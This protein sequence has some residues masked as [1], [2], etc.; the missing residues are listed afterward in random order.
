MAEDLIGQ[1]IKSYE[2]IEQIGRGGFGVVYRARQA[3]VEREVAIKVILPHYACQPEFIRRFECEAQIVA[4]LEHPHI[5]PLYDYW[6]DPDGAFLVMRFLRGGTLKDRMGDKPWDINMT[7]HVIRQLASALAMA[8]QNNIIHRDL[9]P[10]NVLLDERENIYLS[11]FGIAKT[12]NPADASIGRGEF[13]GSPAYVSPE[14]ITGE[15]VGTQTDIYSLGI[16]CFELLSGTHPFAESR[17][18]IAMLNAHIHTPLPSIK[19]FRPDLSDEADEVLHRA[20]AKNPQNRYQD[21]MEFE[22]AFRHSL[23]VV[24]RPV[25]ADAF[26]DLLDADLTPLQLTEIGNP[27]RGLRAFQEADADVFFGRESLT[28]SLLERLQAS[29]TAGRFIALVGPSG[30][31]KSSVVRAGLLPA[32]RRGEVNGSDRWF[33]VEMLP[34][35]HPLEEL[36]AGLLRVAVNPPDTLYEQLRSDERGLVRAIKRCLPDD[37][38]TELLLFID[39]FEEAF[40]L[41]TDPAEREH[42]LGMLYTALSDSNSRLRLVITLRADFYDR[43]LLHPHFGG[44][45]KDHTELVLP[46]SPEELERAITEPARRAKVQLEAGLA[47]AIIGDVHQEP[48]ALPL[49]Q[50]AMTELYDRRTGNTLTLE[51]YHTIGGAMGALARRA[52]ELYLQ[53]DAGQREAVRQLFLRLVTL[54]EGAEDTRRRAM[55]GELLHLGGHADVMQSVVDVLGKARL[56]TFDRDPSTRSATVEVAH[57]ELL[58][59]WGRLRG[60]LD[61]SREDIRQQRR[62]ASLADDWVQSGR[63]ASV[64]LRGSRL[65]EVAAWAVSTSL[66]LSVNERTFLEVSQEARRQQV[67]AEYNRQLREKAL[68]QQSRNRL[69]FLVG[70]FAVATIAGILLSLFAFRQRDDAR[71]ARTAA[72][73]ARQTSEAN[74]VIAETQAAISDRRAQELQSLSLVAAARLNQSQSPDLALALGLQ[75]AQIDQPPTEVERFLNELANQVGT[76]SILTGHDEAVLGLALD[77]EGSLVVSSAGDELWLWD[78]GTGEKIREYTLGGEV[79]RALAINGSELLTVSEAYRVR[80]L[81]TGEVL[82]EFPI[83][84]G[85]QIVRL[86]I[87]PDG[88]TF[89]SASEDGVLRL[90][91][92]QS[93]TIIHRLTGHERKINA[94][95]Y[96][97]DGQSAV[98][99]SDDESFILWDLES[100]EIIRRVGVATGAVNSLAVSPDG[101]TL[102]YSAESGDLVYLELAT[103]NFLQLLRGD[104]TPASVLRFSPDGK[105]ALSAGAG[106]SIILWDLG[107]GLPLERLNGHRNA[108]NDLAIAADPFVLVSA[109]QDGEIRVWDMSSLSNESRRL[110]VPG[111]A[112]SLAISPDGK[113]IATGTGSSLNTRNPS[114]IGIVLWDAETGEE[115]TRLEGH[116]AGVNALAFSP[117]GNRLLSTDGAGSLRVWDTATWEE[118]WNRDDQDGQLFR[119]VFSP[120]GNTILAGGFENSARL[121]N[122]RTGEVLRVFAGGHDSQVLAVAFSPDGQLALTGG[123]DNRIVVWEAATGK[124]IRRY[125]GHTDTVSSLAVSPDGKTFLSASFDNTVLLWDMERGGTR[126]RLAEHIQPVMRAVFSP[127]GVWILSASLDGSAKLWDVAGGYVLDSYTPRNGVMIDGVFSPDG[128]TAYTT[129]SS[130]HQWRLPQQRGLAELVAW[131]RQ[132]RYVRPMTCQEREV[133]LLDTDCE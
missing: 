90:W 96:L 68:E 19:Q 120:D 131:L 14:W 100:G 13:V 83:D 69:R 34:G 31:G 36:E 105:Y 122:A 10:A 110:D 23:G 88:Q 78:M 103:L 55:L 49:L 113:L 32:L 41:V 87:S 28:A 95:A 3:L 58:R 56:L 124:V 130:L 7:V 132:N 104:K 80:D 119:A 16:M 38:E 114:F 107:N 102:L 128:Q 8:H 25:E 17:S 71:Q 106:G 74:V 84:D 45:M 54:G 76:R 127:D 39:Q 21:V 53:L 43:P 81:S 24:S 115:I 6:R 64:L 20:T 77:Q 1:T 116:E 125:E 108:I 126:H 44:L 4:R 121:L 91:D 35:E 30:I 118:L 26:A 92:Y 12:R 111:S 75:A 99:G 129:T 48:G 42:F 51:A 109:D 47:A 117:A 27:Y 65:E 133:Y 63:D 37:E 70:V 40:T 73:D 94:V 2:L 46:L 101:T 123:F 50:Y 60:W 15:G 82:R 93:G 67:M 85:E 29:N 57:E 59:R 11:D 62:L 22:R 52:E 18:P 66:Q 79:I 112:F 33:M 61:T 98:S 89:L 97:P 72:D 86:A 9:K 5:V